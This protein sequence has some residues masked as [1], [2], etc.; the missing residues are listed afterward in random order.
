MLLL[1]MRKDAIS[2]NI[3]S[4]PYEG[5]NVMQTRFGASWMRS[6]FLFLILFG[7]EFDVDIYGPISL[8][9]ISLLLIL[10]AIFY[11]GVPR[12]LP[13]KKSHIVFSGMAVVMYSYS[14]IIQHLNA[15]NLAIA[16]NSVLPSIQI[17]FQF[18]SFFVFPLL[19]CQTFRSFDEFCRTQ[20]SIIVF[21]SMVAIIARLNKPFRMYIYHHF[22]D[23]PSGRMLDN[24][25]KGVRVCFI[26]NMGAGASWILFVG[27]IICTYFAI[28]EKK[29]VYLV[30]YALIMLSMM[31]VGR[32]GLYMAL[33]LLV[34]L[35]CYSISV[36]GHI[37]LVRALLFVGICG[38]LAIVAYILFAPES[39][40]KST[41][42]K[43]VGEIFI[44]GAK[45]GSTIDILIDMGIPPLTWETFWGTG[46]VTGITQS[47]LSIY[48]DVGYV[49][50]YMAFGLVGALL[51]Y[52][53]AYGFFARGIRKVQDKQMRLVLWIFLAFI[54]F[55]ELKEPFLRKTPNA[56]VL[57]TM[58]FTQLRWQWKGQLQ[59]DG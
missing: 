46:I 14:A 45:E 10:F 36:R 51:Y 18:L 21:Q 39:Y 47:G 20:L 35:S 30:I 25:E 40:L 34:F 22:T 17:I 23:D 19:V 1:L 5:K 52:G 53:W 13:I 16:G 59:K 33:I 11:A 9:K 27:C 56:M 48:S 8:R 43:W 3:V 42:I 41:T 58:I 28:K 37:R 38:A 55:V 32:T 26:G 50:H 49:Q 6:S 29:S 2:L 24:M 57:A 15:E 4:L 7:I 12:K 54:V 44:K 31:F